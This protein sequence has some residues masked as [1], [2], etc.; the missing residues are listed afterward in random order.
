MSL[1]GISSA[2]LFF[3]GDGEV[4]IKVSDFGILGEII[5]DTIEG[6]ILDDTIEGEIEI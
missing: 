4:I 6:E 1:L 3:G 5:E 2:G